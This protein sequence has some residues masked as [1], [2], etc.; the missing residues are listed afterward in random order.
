MAR[1]RPHTI[2]KRRQ[3]SGLGV[4]LI[5]VSTD[6]PVGDSPLSDPRVLLL[7]GAALGAGI[8]TIL[9]TWK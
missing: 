3:M 8:T 7:L 4:D 2:V 6:A 9:F 1:P 5:T